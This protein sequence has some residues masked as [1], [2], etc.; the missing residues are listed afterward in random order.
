MMP[1]GSNRKN[2]LEFSNRML[3]YSNCDV[4]D[5][6]II[7]GKIG[8]YKCKYQ[9]KQALSDKKSF[10]CRLVTSHD[11][12]SSRSILPVACGLVTGHDYPSSQSFSPVACGLVAGHDYPSSWSF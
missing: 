1:G 10:L 11:F 7:L 3:I 9:H 2:G 5:C 8:M 4:K 12:T 6:I